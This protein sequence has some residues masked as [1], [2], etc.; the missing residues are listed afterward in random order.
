MIG[1]AFLGVQRKR[2]YIELCWSQQPL[3]IA[4]HRSTAGS[5][6]TEPGKYSHTHECDLQPWLCVEP[7]LNICNPIY[8]SDR[9]G[10]WR[11]PAQDRRG[12]R[13][14]HAERGDPYDHTESLDY[15]SA[16]DRS[17]RSART[18]HR[19]RDTYDRRSDRERWRSDATDYDYR[20][21]RDRYRSDD[22][23]GD[24]RMNRRSRP[25]DDPYTQPRPDRWV[26]P[27]RED[28]WEEDDA[29]DAYEHREQEH[30][31][32]EPD[33]GAAQD[34]DPDDPEAQMAA[35]MGFG[36]FDSSK[37]KPVEGNDV[38]YAHIKK[39]RTWRQYMNRCVLC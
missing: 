16:D 26:P 36:S 18:V 34:A 1:S 27:P 30:I 7:N 24:R 10:G 38:G 12:F 9:T 28:R 15:G 2:V 4:C 35:I 23:W 22:S 21:G 39:E 32:E 14:D 19:N 8:M 17:W 20:S 31:R 5:I 6:L 29:D 3:T 33:K 25:R 37:G 11:R 13:G